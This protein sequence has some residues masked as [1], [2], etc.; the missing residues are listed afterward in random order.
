MEDTL[1]KLLQL[2]SL[3]EEVVIKIISLVGWIIILIGVVK[4]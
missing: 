1:K 3:I 2:L 4:G